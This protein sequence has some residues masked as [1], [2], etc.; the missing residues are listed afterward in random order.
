MRL[1]ETLWDSLRLTG[2][3]WDSLRLTETH[4]DS[5]GFTETHISINL[6]KTLNIIITMKSDFLKR[7]SALLS[8]RLKIIKIGTKGS[9]FMNHVKKKKKMKVTNI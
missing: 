2:T 7:S 6:G 9:K 5:L 3:H 1:T 8:E 4:W